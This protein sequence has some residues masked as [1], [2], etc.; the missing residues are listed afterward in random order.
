MIFGGIL[1]LSLG[2]PLGFIYGGI[3]TI[4]SFGIIGTVSAPIINK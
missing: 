4:L 3:K 2:T 1:G